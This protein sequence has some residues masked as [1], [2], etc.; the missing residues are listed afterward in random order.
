MRKLMSLA[1]LASLVITLSACGE[2]TERISNSVQSS[3]ASQPVEKKDVSTEEKPSRFESGYF[4]KHSL[5][6]DEI[7]FHYTLRD[8]KSGAEHLVVTSGSWNNDAGIGMVQLLDKNGNP[9]VIKNESVDIRGD[10]FVASDVG[11][12]PLVGKEIQFHYVLIDKYTGVQYLVVTSGSW[13]NDA[14]ITISPILDENKK[15]I[16][17]KDCGCT[18]DENKGGNE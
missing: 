3:N 2:S 4:G 18:I 5:S 9:L 12:H 10:R 7:Q 6:D 15:P 8:K 16:I 14:G 1:L 11:K 17:E 13:N